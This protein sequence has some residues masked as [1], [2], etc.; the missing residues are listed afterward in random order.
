MKGTEMAGN[1]LQGFISILIIFIVIG[2]AIKNDWSSSKSSSND[3]DY[4][5]RHTVQN[6]QN[7]YEEILA[8][9]LN[10]K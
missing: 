8:N 10:L 2:V 1:E 4:W 7:L 5:K 3:K 9:R 6:V